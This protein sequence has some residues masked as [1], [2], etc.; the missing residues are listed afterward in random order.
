MKLRLYFVLPDFVSARRIADDLL[1]ARLQDKHMHFLAKRGTDLGEL[2]EASF[3]QKSDMA[4]GASVGLFAG[5]LM[6][7]LLG[8]ALLIF[9]PAGV[10]LQ[11]VTILITALLGAVFGVW[12]STMV[13]LQVPNSR[14]T[15]FE[16]AIECGN[17]LLILDLP[18]RNVEK[19]RDFMKQHHPEAHAAGQESTVP[20]FP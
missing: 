4:H 5:G 11:P 18:R 7:T 15:T 3:L 16:K 6:G 13:G 19:I 14:L 9:P 2:H 20:A 12:V 10:S 17:I 1:L 8:V